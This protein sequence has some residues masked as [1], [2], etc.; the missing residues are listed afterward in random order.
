MALTLITRPVLE[1]VSLDEAM[2]QCRVTNTDEQVLIARYILAARQH[3]ETYTRRA[4]VTQTWR[5]TFDYYWPS[6]YSRDSSWA[7]GGKR[8]RIELAKPPLISVTSLTYYDTT[9]VVQTLDPTQ[10]VTGLLDSG[11]SAIEPVYGVLWP[12]VQRRL[13]AISVTFTAG[14]GDDVSTLPEQVPLAILMMV[15]DFYDNRGSAM[16]TEQYEMPL[17]VCELLNDLRVFY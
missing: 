5:Q 8:Y 15:S 16:A 14:Y 17:G 2:Q 1:P 10:Y 7:Y 11:V 12:T 13:E 6:Q 3:A 9:G 4:L